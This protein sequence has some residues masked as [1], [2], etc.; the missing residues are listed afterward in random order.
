MKGKVSVT[1]DGSLAV[2]VSGDSKI[3]YISL[4][5]L[6]P[7]V[8]LSDQTFWDNVAISKDGKRLA[9]I[10]TEVDTSIYVYN[11]SSKEWRTI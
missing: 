5:P 4:D 6:N 8:I 11:F 2:F 3:R 1:D 10:S 9:A 7:E